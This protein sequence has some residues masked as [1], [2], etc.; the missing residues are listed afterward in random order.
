[1]YEV[2]WTVVG[3]IGML[4]VSGHSGHTITVDDAVSVTVT[5]SRSVQVD[6]LTKTVDVGLGKDRSVA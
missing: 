1:M 5:G 4:V 6:G 2:T 3:P